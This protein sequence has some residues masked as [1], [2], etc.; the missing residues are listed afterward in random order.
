MR[1]SW[2]CAIALRRGGAKAIFI[3]QSRQ[4]RRADAR[5]AQAEEMT[6]SHEQ[7]V[8]NKSHVSSIRLHR[9]SALRNAAV[10]YAIHEV[11]HQ[12]DRHPDDQ[13]EP[14]VARQER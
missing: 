5:T 1:Q 11:D 12:S 13:A 4:R 6:A 7:V 3:E 14:G 9:T 10:T 8:F 2:Q